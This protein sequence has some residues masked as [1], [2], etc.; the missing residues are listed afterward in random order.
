M[1][2]RVALAV[3]PHV[4]EIDR[5]P[6]GVVELQFQPEVVGAEFVDAQA[7]LAE[8][9][10]QVAQVADLRERTKAANDALRGYLSTF[11]LPESAAVFAGLPLPDWVLADMATWVAEVYGRRPTGLSSG[12]AGS[13][14]S[15][16]QPS[17]PA[18]PPK[19][20][21][22]TRGRSRG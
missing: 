20:P 15:S 8:Q 11:M 10:D 2:K 9:R 17:T 13:P 18:G 5:G 19:A 3:E 14:T 4:Y 6:D 12:S 1:R 7:T 21:T 16:G 22:R